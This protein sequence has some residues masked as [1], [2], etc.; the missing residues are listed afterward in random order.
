MIEVRS[1]ARNAV[2]IGALVG[3][4][5]SGLPAHAQERREPMGPLRVHPQNP[6]YFTDGRGRER[7]CG[8]P[9]A[10]IRTCGITAYGSY[11]GSWRWHCEP[12][13]PRT[14]SRARRVDPALSPGHGL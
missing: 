3:L 6:R 7:P 9:P 14:M 12:A 10:Q 13:T 2:L 5:P 1:V 11:L 8:R 4:M